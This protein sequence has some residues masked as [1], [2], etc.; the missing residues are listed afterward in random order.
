MTP[1]DI[2]NFIKDN[3]LVKFNTFAIKNRKNIEYYQLVEI[4]E[5]DSQM[6]GF[7]EGGVIKEDV[8]LPVELWDLFNV[9]E[10]IIF[11]QDDLVMCEAETWDG[12]QPSII[13]EKYYKT[14]YMKDIF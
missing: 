5:I 3:N 4:V 14:D 1:K 6:S 2:E 12:W 8:R 11:D 7:Y 10:C 13:L 9:F